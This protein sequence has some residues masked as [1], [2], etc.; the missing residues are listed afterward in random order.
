M[1][2]KFICVR[3]VLAYLFMLLYHEVFMANGLNIPRNMI[4]R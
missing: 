2:S 4:S 3:V 1:V